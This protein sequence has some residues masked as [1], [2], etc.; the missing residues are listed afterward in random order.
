MSDIIKIKLY[1]G[2]D[3]PEVGVVSPGEWENFEKV[4]LTHYFDGFNVVDS[5]GYWEGQKED[6]KIVT[7]V[8][9]ESEKWR[10]NTAAKNYCESFNQ[11]SVMVVSIPLISCE[12]ITNVTTGF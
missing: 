6:S 4:I 9:P 8:L 11:E 7:V 5:Y 3:K 2:L 10:A 1:F 12:F